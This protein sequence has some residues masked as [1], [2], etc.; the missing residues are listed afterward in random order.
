MNGNERNCFRTRISVN[1]LSI[2]GAVSDLCVTNANLAMLE[3]GDL[4]WWD[5]SDPLFVPTKCDENTYT[6]D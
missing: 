1:Q 5:K 4:F 3:K 2:Y 6:F